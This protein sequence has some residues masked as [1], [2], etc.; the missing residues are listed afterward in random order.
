MSTVCCSDTERFSSRGAVPKNSMLGA[1]RSSAACENHSTNAAMPAWATRPIHER[2]SADRAR[3]QGRRSSMR[4]IA[5]VPSAPIAFSN[6]RAVSSRT[7]SFTCTRLP[8]HPG[9]VRNPGRRPGAARSQHCDGRDQA[10]DQVRHAEQHGGG[11]QLPLLDE[12]AH[13]DA[14][15]PSRRRSC[16]SSARRSRPGRTRAW[17]SALRAAARRRTRSRRRRRARCR[18]RRRRR[19]VVAF[20]LRSVRTRRLSLPGVTRSIT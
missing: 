3:N 15:P 5:A 11:L 20:G 12:P 7:R 19:G 14:R 1:G 16:R 13:R 9:R 4:A 18:S 6:R 17:R 10:D 2:S 8:G